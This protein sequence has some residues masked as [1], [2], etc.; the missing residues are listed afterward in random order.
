MGRDHSETCET[1]GS[2]RGGINDLE[3]ECDLEEAAE[4]PQA[5]VDLFR[6]ALPQNSLLESAIDRLQTERDFFAHTN[7]TLAV[8]ISRYRE[9]YESKC[10]EV[11]QLRLEVQQLNDVITDLQLALAKMREGQ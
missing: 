8:D 4:P 7:A 6:D 10:A 5:L 11:T 2:Q 9:L 3:C 1:C